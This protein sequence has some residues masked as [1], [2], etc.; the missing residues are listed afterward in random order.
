MPLLSFTLHF[1]GG[2]FS[3]GIDSYGRDWRG[4]YICR[5]LC[6][7]F[8]APSAMS[9]GS[10]PLSRVCR[11]RPYRRMAHRVRSF[12]RRVIFSPGAEEEGGEL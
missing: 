4:M 8:A 9:S 7:D 6:R 10:P 2:I 5:R 1:K 12:S 11:R 3:S